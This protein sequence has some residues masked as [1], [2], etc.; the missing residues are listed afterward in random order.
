[1]QTTD[2]WSFAVSLAIML[3]L[4]G[5]LLYLA[6][7]IQG[8]G[9]PGLPARRLRILES[10]SLGPRQ[11]LVLLRFRDQEILVGVSAQQI[12]TLA[13]FAALPAD[14]AAGAPEGGERAADGDPLNS[15][16]TRMTEA[17]RST[18]SGKDKA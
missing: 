12:T 15:L 6:K 2:G 5:A 18:H 8:R 13:T 11:K 9:L 16:S 1:M 10:A 7:R 17:L 14:A 3:A 4:L